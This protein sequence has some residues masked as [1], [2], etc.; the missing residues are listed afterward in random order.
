MRL[1]ML[2]GLFISLL[3][4]VLANPVLSRGDDGPCPPADYDCQVEIVCDLDGSATTVRRSIPR[5]SSVEARSPTINWIKGSLGKLP[6]S[7]SGLVKVPP[8]KKTIF[9]SGAF[10]YGWK[11]PDLVAY[12]KENNGIL[13]RDC[14]DDPLQL[15][16]DAYTDVTPA[17]WA[18]FTEDM[19]KAFAV[20]TTEAEPHVILPVEEKLLRPKAHWFVEKKALMANQYVKK[21]WRFNPNTGRLEQFWPLPPTGPM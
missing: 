16:K 3:L 13:L 9:H 10:N 4:P 20:Q 6:K 17:K 19:C 15:W 12:A 14:L 8:G 21:I 1:V 2:L 7:A 11:W 18:V 5:D